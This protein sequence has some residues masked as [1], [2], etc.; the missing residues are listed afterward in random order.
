[1]LVQGASALFLEQ[2]NSIV[3]SRVTLGVS[4][5]FAINRSKEGFY[6]HSLFRCTPN[7]L[8]HDSS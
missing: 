5:D 6:T 3:T 2:Y 8:C 1:M 7:I 4:Q